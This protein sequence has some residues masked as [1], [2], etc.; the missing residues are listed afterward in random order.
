MT[1][2]FQFSLFPNGS[3]WR[4][5]FLY[6]LLVYTLRLT[7]SLVLTMGNAGEKKSTKI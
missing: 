6:Y 3:N 1:E 4:R 2:N 5:I 7:Q